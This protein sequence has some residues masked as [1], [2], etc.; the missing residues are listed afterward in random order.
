MFVLLIFSL[1]SLALHH[2]GQGC[3]QWSETNRGGK[4]YASVCQMLL[5]LK[6]YKVRL[7][8]YYVSSRDIEGQSGYTTP[9][10]ILLGEGPD[11][12]AR[13]CFLCRRP[14]GYKWCLCTFVLD[15]VFGRCLYMK[16]S[17][18][19]APQYVVSFCARLFMAALSI[20]AASTFTH[21]HPHV[22]RGALWPRG[23]QRG[24]GC[25]TCV[26][27]DYTSACGCVFM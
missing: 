5:S 19:V 27:S 21:L 1:W 7:D 26:T 14:Y 15:E 12:C 20:A 22:R 18:Y 17:Q 8:I 3:V 24:G 2:R 9:M 13:M 16:W 25:C 4:V 23:Q 10:P 6:G 11:S